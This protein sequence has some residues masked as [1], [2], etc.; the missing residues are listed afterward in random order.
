MTQAHPISMLL[1]RRSGQRRQGCATAA[2]MDLP[3][4][5]VASSDLDPEGA[6]MVLVPR[7]DGHGDVLTGFRQA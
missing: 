4:A 6:R 3:K 2:I 1:A 5:V 7:L